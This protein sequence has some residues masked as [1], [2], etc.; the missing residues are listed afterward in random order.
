MVKV[1]RTPIVYITMIHIGPT[2]EERVIEKQRARMP[3]DNQPRKEKERKENS[4]KISD[5]FMYQR[6][7]YQDDGLSFFGS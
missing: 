5:F 1:G 6:Q 2:D 4:K 3:I 7:D